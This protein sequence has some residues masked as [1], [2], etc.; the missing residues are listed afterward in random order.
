[1]TIKLIVGLGNP[2]PQYDRTRHNV[3][4]DWVKQIASRYA[5]TLTP[6]AKFKGDLGRG[7][8]EGTDLRLLIPTTFMNLS[9]EAVGP[10]AHYFKIE[11]AEILVAHDEVAFAPGIVKLKSGGGDNGHNGLRSVRDGLANSGDYHR[12]R[13]GVGHP[14]DK[15]RVTAYLTQIKIPVSEQQLIDDALDI[16][17]QTLKS[18]VRGDIQEAMNALHGRGKQQPASEDSEPREGDKD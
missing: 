4:A 5:V 16:P 13:I 14:G 17:G 11:P 10:L 8:V 9:G 1:M 7:L 15:S 3:G 6:D 18:I 2:G 12:L